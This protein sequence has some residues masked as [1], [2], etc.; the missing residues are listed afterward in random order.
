M[1]DVLVVS[2]AAWRRLALAVACAALAQFLP[3]SAAQSEGSP[4]AES[5]PAALRDAGVRYVL[6]AGLDKNRF[7]S[8]VPGARVAWSGEELLLL[9]L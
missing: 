7:L 1:T 8:Q 6:V 4:L 9:R 2:G 5:S 3:L